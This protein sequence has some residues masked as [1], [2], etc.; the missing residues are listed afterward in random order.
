M[1]N[2]LRTKIRLLIILFFFSGLLQG[3]EKYSIT[4]D[5]RDLTFDEFVVKTENQ[6]GVRFFYKPDWVSGLRLSQYKGCTSLDC[7]LDSL[8][9]RANLNYII[10]ETGRVIITG[11]YKVKVLDAPQETAYDMVPLTMFINSTRDQGSEDIKTITIGNVSEKNRTGNVTI[12]GYIL[13]RDTRAPVEGV[14]IYIQKLS[15][16]SITNEKGFYSL[17]LLYRT[18]RKESKP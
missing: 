16:G 17:S 12:S 10:D 18:D 7:I 2:I 3:Q 11:K 15:I 14:N 9:R 4:F 1:L 8:F 6:T 5:Y 13:N